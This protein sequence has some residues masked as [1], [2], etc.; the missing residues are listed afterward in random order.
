MAG[1]PTLLSDGNRSMPLSAWAAELGISA[2]ALY[3]RLREGWDL[4]EALTTPRMKNSGVK[5]QPSS[6]PGLF[7]RSRRCRGCIYA[8]RLNDGGPPV[9]LY[10]AYLVITGKRRPTPA[11]TCPG[12]GRDE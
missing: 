7:E 9:P 11:A 2:S 5:P 4:H 6:E 10:C 8:R 12:Y 1:K 3:S